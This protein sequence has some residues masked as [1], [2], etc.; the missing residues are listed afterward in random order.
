[1]VQVEKYGNFQPKGKSK[2]KKQIILT[3]TSRNIE[4]YL[5]SVSFRF[6]KKYN[7]IPNYIID[8]EGKIYNL[9]SDLEYTKFF[10]D[11]SVNKNSIIITLENLG[12]LYKEPLKDYYVNWIGDIY[13][14]KVVDRKWRDY[15]FWQPYTESQI[16][17]TAFL[18]KKLFID[19]KIN[20]DV[21]GNNTKI[22]GIERFEGVTTRS[23]Y[24]V[25]YTDL[26]PAFNFELFLK[27]IEN[28]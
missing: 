8:R 18:C 20:N 9:I 27:K 17:S 24:D 14:G 22:N 7:K 11:E 16:N 4:D 21:I 6:N 15:F 23:N 12:W 3:H 25:N 2:E 1:M 10:N 19:M 26:S 28:E 5:N 13:N